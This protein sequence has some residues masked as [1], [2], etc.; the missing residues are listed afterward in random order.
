MKTLHCA[1][2]LQHI[3]GC[4]SLL[5]GIVDTHNFLMKWIHMQSFYSFFS[6]NLF[7]LSVCLSLRQTAARKSML[8][9]K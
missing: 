2:P 3:L 5:Y 4:S 8:V 7:W 1:H 6:C 9:M